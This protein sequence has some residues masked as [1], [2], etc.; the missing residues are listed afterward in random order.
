MAR[1]ATRRGDSTAVIEHQLVMLARWLEAAQRKQSYPMDRAS[2]LLLLRLE[3]D[4][5]QRVAALAASLGLD[6]S[7]V[8]RQL[9]ALDTRGWVHRS[10]DPLDARVTVVAAT[11]AGLAAMDDL[12]G[13]RQARIDALFGDWSAA[14]QAEL[15]RVLGHLNEVLERNA[16]AVKDDSS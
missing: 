4:G 7:T 13:F 8:T 2:Y 11:D 15:G 3:R 12:R 5:P 6:G 1:T 9:A 16:L 10:T 14:E